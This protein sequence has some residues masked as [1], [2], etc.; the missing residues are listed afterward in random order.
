[1]AEFSFYKML[2]NDRLAEM[3]HQEVVSGNDANFALIDQLRSYAEAYARFNQLTEAEVSQHYRFFAS[4]FM[5]DL[6]AFDKDGQ[7][8]V[9]RGATD[10][11]VERVRYDIAL[12]FS[13]FLTGHRYRLMYLVNLHFPKHACRAACIGCG[14]SLELIFLKNRVDIMEGYDLSLNPFCRHYHPDVHFYEKPFPDQTKNTYDVILAV[15]LL[16]HLSDPYE[17]LRRAHTTLKNGGYILLTT[18]T[19]VPQF[20]HLYNFHA[21]HSFFEKTCKEIG[22]ELAYKEC[23]SHRYLSSKTAAS[24]HFYVFRKIIT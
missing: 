7:Y 16:E 11:T 3:L 9:Q 10:R 12:L 13:T 24:N 6:K 5:R 14:P 17:L 21:D 20:D 22:F 19:N 1:M 23:I 8:P 18:A 15:E 2:E 4:A